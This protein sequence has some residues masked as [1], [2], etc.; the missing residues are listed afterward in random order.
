VA[1]DFWDNLTGEQL[2][3]AVPNMPPGTAI[4][5]TVMFRDAAGQPMIAS[6]VNRWIGHMANVPV[7]VLDDTP[8]GT[9]AVGGSLG[10]AE[11]FAQ[12]AGEIALRVLNGAPIADFPFEIRTRTVPTFDWRALERWGIRERA[13]P[14]GSV[15]RFKPPSLWVQYRWYV[16]GALL[17]IAA[18]SATIVA[19]IVQRRRR[20]RAE[21]EARQQRA[22]LAH[23]GRVS[24]MGELAAAL[25]H[26]LSQPLTAIYANASAGL[27]A[28]RQGQ[29]DA[30]EL[31]EILDDVIKDQTRAAEVLRHMRR[32]VKKETDLEFAAVDVA[33]VIAEVVALVRNDAA[34]E[35]VEIT[36]QVEPGL[37]PV[38][39]DRVQ[40]QQVLLNLLLN[41]LD[42]M[43]AVPRRARIVALHA[44]SEGE[45]IEVAV[46]DRGRGIAANNVERV[47]EPFY[48]T[49]GEG[50][51]MGLSICRSI[52]QAHGG[53]LWAVNNAEGG[54][55]FCFTLPAR[56][57]ERADARS[58]GRAPSPAHPG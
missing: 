3:R 41:A 25:A 48:T 22:E 38:L 45:M 21:R 33:A 35:H 14:P 37:P 13:L 20:Q 11:A 31:G 51:G 58:L 52:I 10:S 18:Q 17:I 40:L 23:V 27:R 15:V 54:A 16:A 6:E 30:A 56:P 1:I 50:L 2:R 8:L 55:T 46:R 34:L 32:M 43:K 53:R 39:G 26:E 36:L 49:K 44:R 47:F 4:L 19:L 9:G 12:R 28:L 42:A 24:L 57:A 7:Y 5:L 29:H